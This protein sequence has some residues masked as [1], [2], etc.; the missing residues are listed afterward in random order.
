MMT[1]MVVALGTLEGKIASHH[2]AVVLALL[3]IV[4]VLLLTWHLL[5][6]RRA[7]RMGYRGWGAYL[8][9]VPK[10][11]TEKRMAVDMAARGVVWCILG[12]LFPPFVI[13]GLVPLYYGGR[14]LL[15][16]GAG[17]APS[18]SGGPGSGQTE[19]GR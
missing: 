15:M 16:I 5:Q 18:T 4:I 19:P 2:G 8:R 9:A 11:D 1:P 3:A 14:K 6:Q 17:V 12:I 7:R 10:N 13:V